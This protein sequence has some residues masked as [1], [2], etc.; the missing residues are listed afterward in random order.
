MMCKIKLQVFITSILYLA[1]AITNFAADNASTS[2]QVTIPALVQ[3]SGLSNITLAP[4]NFGS[5][6]IGSTTACIYT[7][8]ISPLGS[9]YVTASSSNASSGTFRLANGGSFISYN[10]YWNNTSAATQNVLLT[11]GIKTAQQS[12]GNDTA[13]TCSGTPNANFNIR[14]TSAQVTG[15]APATYTD[16]VTIVISPT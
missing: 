2:V 8:V 1:Y 12:G 11:S 16:T 3:I 15:V 6:V 10:A 9:Y 14:I 5:P 7:N 4:T 13:L